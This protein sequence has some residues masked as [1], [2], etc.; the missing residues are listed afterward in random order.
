MP[1][2]PN[3]PIQDLISQYSSSFGGAAQTKPTLPQNTSFTG[4]IGRV[5]GTGVE[6]ATR[7]ITS[8]PSELGLTDWKP[9]I[10]F[11]DDPTTKTGK[12]AAIATELG[13]TAAQFFI[14]FGAVVKGASL[15]A[16]LGTLGKGAATASA[17]AAAAGK[18]AESIRVARETSFTAATAAKAAAA[19]AKTT[20][21]PADILAAETAIKAASDAK[22]AITA[23]ENPSTLGA[24]IKKGMGAGAVT[25]YIAFSPND[26]GLANLISQ[27]PEENKW[28]V[29]AEIENLLAT[30]ENDNAQLNR[31]RHVLEGLGMGA[32][33]PLILRGISKGV[34]ATG[35]IVG[36]AIPEFIK[37]PVVRKLEEWNNDIANSMSGIQSAYDRAVSTGAIADDPYKYNVITNYRMA[38]D[39]QK[40][41]NSAISGEG[42]MSFDRANGKWVVTGESMQKIVRETDKFGPTGEKDFADYLQYTTLNE[43]SKTAKGVVVPD[44]I[45]AQELA[46]LKALPHYA[47]LT[48]LGNRMLDFNS[49]MLD[50]A[51]GLGGIGN[52]MR[53]R[54]EYYRDI[55][56][57]SPVSGRH[58]YVPLYRKTEIE[59]FGN[60][61]VTKKLEARSSDAL[62]KR[63]DDYSR[64]SG[65]TVADWDARRLKS[66]EENPIGD[67]FQNLTLSYNSMIAH[68]LKNFADLGLVDVIKAMGK[69]GETYMTRDTA[70]KVL[71]TTI[72]RA[73]LEAWMKNNKLA[74]ADEILD[75]KRRVSKANPSKR[76]V[77]AYDN[78]VGNLFYKF[79][80]NRMGVSDNTLVVQRD[81]ITEYWTV[82]DPLVL[83]SLQ[84]LG[85]QMFSD[86]A[87]N[88]SKAAVPVKS[89]LTHMVTLNPAFIL[90]NLIRD[91]VSVAILSKGGYKAFIS[92]ARGLFSTFS[93]SQEYMDFHRQGGGYSQGYMGGDTALVVDSKNMDKFPGFMP[94]ATNYRGLYNKDDMFKFTS[95]IERQAQ[96][97]EL[98]SRT[99]EYDR[100][101][102]M[103]YDPVRAAQ[104][105]AEV[106]TDFARKGSSNG[107]RLLTN[108]VPF[109]N[110]S[111]QGLHRFGRAIGAKAVIGKE[112]SYQ[113]SKEA[114]Q[115][116]SRLFSMTIAGGVV[117][118][119]Y[120]QMSDDPEVV[121]TYNNVSSYVKNLNIV[122]VL[123]KGV[124]PGSDPN[125]PF[126][127]TIPKPFDFGILLTVA[128]KVLQEGYS[129]SERNVLY[130]YVK[131]QM[132]QT[133]F[134]GGEGGLMPQIIKPWYDIATNTNFAGIPIVPEGVESTL[135][136]RKYN[137]RPT[138]LFIGEKLGVSP[139]KVEHLI[140]GYFSGLG[141]LLWD[142]TLDPLARAGMGLPDAPAKRADE[143]AI[144]KSFIINGPLRFSERETQ[145]YD[146]ANR[147]KAARQDFESLKKDQDDWTKAKY[148][149]Y[150]NDPDN[151]FWREQYPYL[152]K[153]LKQLG[154]VN[155]KIKYW[156]KA[157]PKNLELRNTLLVQKQRIVDVYTQTFHSQNERRQ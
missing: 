144:A 108:T 64:K 132:W 32:A 40:V 70:K 55:T 90:K 66:L 148:E 134:R 100:L 121:D 74:T 76:M 24:S 4:E 9:E 118:P 133:L 2:N 26:P 98:A 107:F 29:L 53:N 30:D 11:V 73:Q 46:R 149:K 115:V 142:Y 36:K 59:E 94:Q 14:P 114:K 130:E 152:M 137:T 56:G 78:D 101:I 131:W 54:L 86:G 139:L 88:W 104:E 113:E 153:S 147:S 157:D 119:M 5:I 44:Q 146:L 21:A 42:T 8:L 122:I 20:A 84:S 75:M 80:T 128:E 87:K 27:I 129:P 28:A 143:G 10:D 82:H 124:V 99:V 83:Q 92:A 38:R 17:E 85:P 105:A 15:V 116:W 156:S 72:S 106:A 136:Q 49:R 138:A 18:L 110:A 81:G 48:L 33:V 41:L 3:A 7:A 51:E 22:K 50:F 111:I 47:E 135:A 60:P 140:N 96:R 97:V 31:F 23:I 117:L 112:L 43:L 155:D 16:K 68:E 123:P 109:L 35:G 58:M 103:G 1:L 67:V 77:D 69:D 45:I 79:R 91:T 13:I 95:W 57:S 63:R 89:L 150:L 145:L 61:Y 34:S 37:A 19:T 52:A 6:R 71:L 12:T 141:S 127:V 102:K 39:N 120:H 65:E 25:D 154:E 125:Y 62:R 126:V 151:K 93:N